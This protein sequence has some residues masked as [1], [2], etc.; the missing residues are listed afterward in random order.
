MYKNIGAYFINDGQ[1]MSSEKFYA[2]KGD[3]VVYEVMRVINGHILFLED[4]VERLKHSLGKVALQA[5]AESIKEQ[6]LRLVSI[7]EQMDKNIKL[8]VVQGH[9]QLYFIE[10]FYPNR[11]FYE[12]GVATTAVQLERNNPTIKQLDMDYK[13]HVEIIK[14]DSFFEVLLINQYNKVIEGSSSN[15]IF[16]KKNTLYSAPLDEILT[17]ITLENV[18]KISETLGLEVKYKSVDMTQ[19]DQM[20]GCFLTGT[21]LGVLP[22]KSIDHHVCDSAKQP[23]VLKLMQAYNALSE[24]VNNN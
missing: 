21:S 16:F 17:G 11:K 15:L 14:G 22:I 18:M 7:N 6:L 3:K 24:S 4:H 9:Y 23:V 19:L 20:D 13:H 12:D 5:D 8:D 1:I 2:L 10:S